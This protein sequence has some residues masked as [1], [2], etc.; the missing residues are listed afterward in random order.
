MM[1]GHFK[2]LV[3]AAL[4]TTSAMIVSTTLV[5]ADEFQLE[6][7]IVLGEPLAR[8]EALV[9]VN[10]ILRIVNAFMS[11][12]TSGQ[13]APITAL[14]ESVYASNADVFR[15]Q[16]FM[17]EQDAGGTAFLKALGFIHDVLGAGTEYLAPLQVCA[18]YAFQPDDGAAGDVDL[19]MS[20]AAVVP[21]FGLVL[22]TV[23]VKTSLIGGVR[24][25]TAH[26]YLTAPAAG[27]DCDGP[28]AAN[29]GAQ[30]SAR[31]Q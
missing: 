6:E 10:G 9:S 1:T 25:I 18:I 28:A 24:Q 15:S 3:L 14:A 22:N 16:E 19:A 12:D 30:W 13:M 20:T 5:A 4:L 21:Q 29:F 26:D 27:E 17:T 8:V 23:L 11:A 7:T 2:Q 31:V